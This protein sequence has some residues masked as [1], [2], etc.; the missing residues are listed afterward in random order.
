MHIEYLFI[1]SFQHLSVKKFVSG[2]LLC[3]CLH[4]AY[5]PEREMLYNKQI[6]KSSRNKCFV[7]YGNLKNIS[8][9]TKTSNQ[10]Q[11][12]QCSPKAEMHCCVRHRHRHMWNHVQI[13]TLL[14]SPTLAGIESL[15]LA[16]Y[17]FP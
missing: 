2:K 13:A 8:E 16:S 6:S 4:G 12:L 3:F 14:A 10:W 7:K 1:A 9:F 15:S 17:E 11:I 5:I